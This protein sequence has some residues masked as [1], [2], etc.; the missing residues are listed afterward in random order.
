MNWVENDPSA[1][2]GASCLTPLTVT[3][4]SS[5]AGSDC[6]PAARVPVN[7]TVL[8]YAAIW[9][10][11]PEK[12]GVTWLVNWNGV[13]KPVPAEAVAVYVPAIALAV[14][15]TLA[16]PL[17]PVT[18]EPALSEA[19]APDDGAV[20]SIVAPGS[21]ALAKSSVKD[22]DQRASERLADHRALRASRD[23]GQ[24]VALDLEGA[25][26]DGAGSRARRA[27]LVGGEAARPSPA[28]MAALPGKRAMVWVGPP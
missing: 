4:T 28:P 15:V 18:A 3:A 20:K 21:G 9:P 24:G 1:A 5:P 10:V 16:W 8:P 6:V 2:S 14:A 19:L 22:D 7:V 13:V 17:V 23:E 25:D 12:L 26:V 27:A 11:S